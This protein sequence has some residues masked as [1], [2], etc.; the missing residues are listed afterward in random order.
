MKLNSHWFD[1]IRSSPRAETATAEAVHVCQHPGC[2]VTATHRAPQGRFREGR[3]FWFCL[4]HVREY[5]KSYNYFSG[6]SD[7]AVRA[8]QKDAATGHRPTWSMGTNGPQPHAAPHAEPEGAR[9]TRGWSFADP[10]DIFRDAMTGFQAKTP[11]PEPRRTLGNAERK[12]LIAL[13]LEESA[14]AEEIKARYKE[15][16]KRL[17]PDA[18]GGDR[19]TEDKLRGVIQAYNYLRKTGL[20]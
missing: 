13:N 12:A 15:L 18:N 3:F 11:P 5:N 10:F 8:F 1:R 20:C 17:H 4:D 14:T 16:V 6:M 9:T 2:G 7:D 19:G